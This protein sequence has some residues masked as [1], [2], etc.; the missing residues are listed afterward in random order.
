MYITILVCLLLDCAPFLECGWKG[1]EL[2][3][4]RRSSDRLIGFIDPIFIPALKQWFMSE[5]IVLSNLV[6][7]VYQHFFIKCFYCV[8]NSINFISMCFSFI[9]LLCLRTFTLIISW[10]V[11]SLRGT[12]MVRD[13]W[14]L[15]PV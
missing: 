13:K 14:F 6:R 3:G 12:R 8:S 1:A 11:L 10:F 5:F 7:L 2:K 4:L 9:R 15:S